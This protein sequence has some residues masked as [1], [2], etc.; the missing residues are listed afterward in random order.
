M[1]TWGLISLICVAVPLGFGVGSSSEIS[2]LMFTLTLTFVSLALTR[3]YESALGFDCA[4]GWSLS[5]SGRLLIEFRLYRELFDS[6]SSFML[7]FMIIFPPLLPLSSSTVSP[8]FTSFPGHGVGRRSDKV[9]ES[10]LTLFERG[11]VSCE[12]F[13]AV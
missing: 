13:V 10:G 9:L 1:C 3:I 8:D 11:L 7:P 2:V 12:K 4:A 5:E 6:F